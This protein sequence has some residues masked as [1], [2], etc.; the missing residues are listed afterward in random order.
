M[1]DAALL[2][3]DT[4]DSEGC[5]GGNA[6]S[7]AA[8]IDPRNWIDYLPRAY[9][10]SMPP[11]GLTTSGLW[12]PRYD[13]S[14]TPWQNVAARDTADADDRLDS[15]VCTIATCGHAA[16]DK[17]TYLRRFKC[18]KALTGEERVAERLVY[19]RFLD[20]TAAERSSNGVD[21]LLNALDDK[22]LEGVRIP[23]KH[24]RPPPNFHNG[25]SMQDATTPA[26]L[27]FLE[28]EL[29]R[30]VESGAMEFGT[31]RKWMSRL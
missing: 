24:N 26:Q 13:R 8:F 22:Q 10:A 16:E 21:A 5:G 20:T 6:A 30:F 14:R 1:D 23:F 29:G 3:D 27:T 17:L 19:F 7:H 11:V 15:A 18:K 2:P 28:G 9:A 4:Y 12:N 25:I 31:F